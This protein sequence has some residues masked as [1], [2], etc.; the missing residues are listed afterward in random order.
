MSD[1]EVPSAAS[2]A[3]IEGLGSGRAAAL[4]AMLELGRR[5]Y[6]MAGN[7][8][9]APSDI[10]KLIQHYAD[11]PQERFITLSLT[12]AHEVIATRIVT[13][14]LVNKTLVHPRE[15]FANIITDRAA[16][17]VVAHNH[18]SGSTRPSSEDDSVTENLVRVAD[19]LGIHFLDHVIFT[20]TGYFSYCSNG[21]GINAFRAVK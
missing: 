1:K 18:P 11:Y 6:G 20:R 9:S 13:V 16:A 3:D 14:G 2:L 12:G 5:R 21:G 7:K 17:L 4:V 10:F 19:M 15:V 8:I